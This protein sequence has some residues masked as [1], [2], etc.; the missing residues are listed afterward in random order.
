MNAGR[1]HHAKM[2]AL[3]Q[4]Q[5][6]QVLIEQRRQGLVNTI[7]QDSAR[8]W[9]D[10]WR[11]EWLAHAA[12]PMKRARVVEVKTADLYGQAAAS[13]Y[14]WTF[15]VPTLDG[16]TREVRRET[17]TLD[18]AV[19]CDCPVGRDLDGSPMKLTA[20]DCQDG[21]VIPPDADPEI[22]WVDPWLTK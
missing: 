11:S 19:L 8:G 22:V 3:S 13:K 2:M 12:P 6:L 20:C 14:V 5:Q 17:F 7:P 16:G 21:Y 9:L 18:P 1:A 10:Y 4:F 15:T